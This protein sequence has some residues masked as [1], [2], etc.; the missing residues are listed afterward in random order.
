MKNGPIY[1]N[2]YNILFLLSFILFIGC[3][4][5]SRELKKD[6]NSIPSSSIPS[7]FKIF[8]S[9][10]LTLDG[11]TPLSINTT[12]SEPDKKISVTVPYD[13]DLK[14][15]NFIAVFTVSNGASIS[16][17]QVPQQ[18]G[19]TVN[20]FSDPVVYTVTAS[21]GSTTDYTVVTIVSVDKVIKDFKLSLDGQTPLSINTTIS[22][23]DKKISVTVPY[24]TDLKNKNFIAV[25]TVSNGASISIGQVP[26]QSGKTVNNFSDPV[27]YTVMANDGST[28]D[29]TVTVS[30]ATPVILT[31]SVAGLD[32]DGSHEYDA[33]IDGTSIKITNIP[34][35]SNFNNL[36][37]TFTLSP[38]ISS[39]TIGDTADSPQI[40]QKSGSIVNY[41]F[42]QG[43]AVYTVTAAD[44][45]TKTS[46]TVTI[47]SIHASSILPYG[48]LSRSDYLYSK[49]TK[50]CSFHASMQDDGTF[51]IFKGTEK[52]WSSNK[53]N[54]NPNNKNNLITLQDDGNLVIYEAGKQA[55]PYWSSNTQKNPK[56]ILVLQQDGNLVI[57]NLDTK[58]PIW[59]SDKYDSDCEG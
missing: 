37:A 53:I 21:D 39:I 34:Y 29:Y 40:P 44:G 17:G 30:D 35:G 36:I 20:N 42:S 33:I 10:K 55:F 14:N 32:Q 6:S 43:P 41:D 23:P 59:S 4:L 22:E 28:T 8:N 52:W 1:R 12:I 2:I 51:Q 48:T 27:V 18:S 45:F 24:D 7:S 58:T 3:A 19:K 16:I 11:Q 31:Y 38:G 25:F 54:P 57:Y 56:D 46:Y 47:N 13:T 49:P 26:Q 9:Y 15:K 5:N 50:N